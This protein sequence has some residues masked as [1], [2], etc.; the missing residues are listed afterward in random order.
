MP[1]TPV[2]LSDIFLPPGEGLDIKAQLDGKVIPDLAQDMHE[3]PDIAWSAFSEEIQFAFSKALDV[4]LIDV[5]IGAWS[6]LKQLREY[7]GRKP[8]D[9]DKPFSVALAQHEVLSSHQPSVD[10][11]L[12]EKVIGRI[13]VD[14]EL[15]LSLTGI[16]LSILDDHIVAIASGKFS[17]AGAIKYHDATLIEK[18]TKEYEIPGKWTLERPFP[19]P[20]RQDHAAA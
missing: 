10:I 6:K 8:E 19:L 1:A 9:P 4:K 5:V 7:C 13:V 3:L 11:L 2:T 20:C 15:T 17:G 12:G 14:L 18:K 16:V